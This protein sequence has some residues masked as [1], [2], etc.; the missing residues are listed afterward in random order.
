MCSKKLQLE[1]I[2]LSVSVRKQKTGLVEI[3]K[4]LAQKVKLVDQIYCQACRI[5]NKACVQEEFGKS[6]VHLG[7]QVGENKQG[8]YYD[9][10]F[11]HLILKH[12]K[13]DLDNL[14]SLRDMY[15][16]IGKDIDSFQ[17]FLHKKLLW[18]TGILHDRQVFG[19]S[20]LQVNEFQF[21]GF[22]VPCLKSEKYQLTMI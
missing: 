19:T 21:P 7:S 8:G 20:L 5:C 16:T 22:K 10:V 4:N 18:K 14:F 6:Q 13:P 2:R 1:S 17:M 15:K 3:F 12:S 11:D 9:Q